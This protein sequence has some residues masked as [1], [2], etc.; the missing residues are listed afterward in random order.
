MKKAIRYLLTAISSLSRVLTGTAP[1][2]VMFLSNLSVRFL[3]LR[4]SGWFQESV[5]SG[6]WFKQKVSLLGQRDANTIIGN[7][8]QLDTTVLEP[9]VG[10][11]C[12]L[13]S[14]P[15]PPAT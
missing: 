8:A 12:K 5:N 1:L 10:T 13:S 2:F 3:M 11:L 6:V 9:I 7:V 15:E 4:G 14:S